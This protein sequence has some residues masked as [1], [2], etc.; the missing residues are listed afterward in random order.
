MAIIE[1]ETSIQQDLK[2][3][4]VDEVGQVLL[5][6]ADVLRRDGWCRGEPTDPEGRHCAIGALAAAGSTLGATL[7]GKSRL[8]KSLGL[9]AMGVGFW[10][11]QQSGPEPVIEALTRAAYGV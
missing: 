6:A 1:H 8:Q 9:E 5:D 7:R 2:P 10:N 3:A 4:H 11:D